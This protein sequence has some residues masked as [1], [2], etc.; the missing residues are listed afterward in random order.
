M[1]FLALSSEH[2]LKIY[3]DPGLTNRINS[4]KLDEGATYYLDLDE[5]TPLECKKFINDSRIGEYIQWHHRNSVATLQ[6]INVIGNVSLFGI[7]FTVI[8]RK[9]SVGD[10]DSGNSQFQRLLNDINRISK[11][12]N[13][14]YEGVTTSTRI[15]DNK[16]IN[17]SVLER[18]EYYRQIIYDQPRNQ[19]LE[20]LVSFII[21]NKHTKIIRESVKLPISKIKQVSKNPFKSINPVDFVTL[22]E[23]HP[24]SNTVFAKSLS[25]QTSNNYFVSRLASD[26]KTNSVDTLENRFIKY[27]LAEIRNTCVLVRNMSGLDDITYEQGRLISAK[28]EMLLN[29]DFFREIGPLR[30]IP[31]SS[32]V[33]LGRAGYREIFSH[34]ILSRLGFHNIID[35]LNR[36][37]LNTGLKSISDLYEVW[38]FMKIAESILGT[39]VVVKDTQRLFSSGTVKYGFTWQSGECKVIY[40]NS[41]SRT[42]S[43]SYSLTLRPDVIINIADSYYLFDAK[44]K[45]KWNP[46]TEAEMAGF[47]SEDLHKMHCYVDA[48]P[49]ACSS[50][51]VYPGHHRAFFDRTTFKKTDVIPNLK[52]FRGVGTIPLK[53]LDE[54]QANSLSALLGT[55]KASCIHS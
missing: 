47:K 39:E 46:E 18:F 42:R 8:S 53:P 50:F 5:Y 2:A 25:G 21:R 6:F 17:P 54:D 44:Y 22:S 29:F 3:S 15:I 11:G 36:E 38:V 20:T 30:I 41:F 16:D 45:I 52:E 4:G 32:T 37:A 33:L 35:R 48:I 14:K 40:N 10:R 31:T 43:D 12:I 1:V 19:N 55:L 49:K 24:L 7:P 9:M 13:F 26:Q 34:F 28:I 27:F 51:V 23:N